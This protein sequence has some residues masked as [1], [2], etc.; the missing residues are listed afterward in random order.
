MI[1]NHSIPNHN[2]FAIVQPRHT[3]LSES[4]FLERKNKVIELKCPKT[5]NVQKAK[6]IDMWKY[7]LKEE[8]KYMNSFSLLCFGVNSEALTKHLLKTFPELQAYHSEVEIW[9]MEKV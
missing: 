2:Y 1:I 8:F 6:F 4:E 3:S 9:L 7:K 5:G